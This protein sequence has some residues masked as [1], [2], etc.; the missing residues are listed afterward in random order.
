MA[1]QFIIDTDA[2][3]LYFGKDAEAIRVF[4]TLKIQ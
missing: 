3:S 1:K 4:E 2:L